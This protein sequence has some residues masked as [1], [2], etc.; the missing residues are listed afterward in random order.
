MWIFSIGQEFFAREAQS[1][2][3]MIPGSG[4]LTLQEQVCD[5]GA[6]GREGA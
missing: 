1:M 4:E 6:L 2:Q 3:G 5:R